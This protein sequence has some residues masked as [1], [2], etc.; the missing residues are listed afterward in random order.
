MKISRTIFRSVLLGLSLMLSAAYGLEVTDQHGGFKSKLYQGKIYDDRG[1]YQGMI[2]PDG[3]MYDKNGRFTGQIKN[4]AILNSD[5]S[6]DGFIR[7][8]KI[9]DKAGNFKGLLKP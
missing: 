8:G 5:G 7:D 1:K 4:Q 3:K 9:Y 2:T 6:S